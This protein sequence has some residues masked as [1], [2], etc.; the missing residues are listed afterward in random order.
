MLCSHHGIERCA[1]VESAIKKAKSFLAR[2]GFSIKSVSVGRSIKTTHL[3]ILSRDGC[4]INGCGK[5]VLRQSMASA[6]FEALEH[7]YT[8]TYNEKNKPNPKP[9]IID[10]NGEDNYLSSATPYLEKIIKNDELYFSRLPFLDVLTLEKIEYPAFL[11]HPRYKATSPEEL[12]SINDYSL[13]R[14]SSNSGSAA[15]VNI[16]EATLHGMLEL[17]ERDAIGVALL[18]SIFKKNPDPVRSVRLWTLPES[19]QRLLHALSR[20]EN[21]KIEIFDITND[22]SLPSFMSF[23]EVVSTGERFFGSGTSTN[24]EYAVERSILESLQYLHISR[25]I[26]RPTPRRRKPSIVTGIKYISAYL[27]GGIFQYRGGSNSV[28]FIEVNNLAHSL[29]LKIKD[30]ASHLAKI[31]VNFY[32]RVIVDDEVAVV[33]IVAPKLE[34]FHLVARGVIVLPGYRGHQILATN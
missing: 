29:E 8:Q 16:N 20:Q 33:Q 22:T 7:V 6:I 14:Y 3:E 25:H 32:R 28:D 4:C 1:D 13:M 21:V 34:R 9:K 10:L 15:G 18:K 23:I 26:G 30:I 24:S 31:G 17:I 11:V 5:G 12:S 19:I 2:E 27:E